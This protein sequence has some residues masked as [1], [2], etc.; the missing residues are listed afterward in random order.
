MPQQTFRPSTKIVR[1]VYFITLIAVAAGIWLCLAFFQPWAAV[2]P[3]LL[4]LIP[5][6]MHIP[7]L[8]VRLTLDGEHLVLE[9][10]I[11]SKT[12]RTLGLA[13][14]QDVTVHQSMGQRILGLG[15]ISVETA[16]EGS[17]LTAR[18][19]DNPKSLATAILTAAHRDSNVKGSGV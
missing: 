8:A 1:A 10:G 14:V 7:L 11:L 6:R 19:F 15:D 13:K 2:F 18:S 17:A 5:L 9:S 3:L 4:L 16:G 12:T